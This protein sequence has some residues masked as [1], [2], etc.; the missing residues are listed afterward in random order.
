MP[1]VW[2]RKVGETPTT[3]SYAFGD[4]PDAVRGVVVI[5]VDDVDACHLEG[6]TRE[7]LGPDGAAVCGK[8]VRTFRAS[9]AWPQ[10]AHHFS[11]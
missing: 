11:C 2:G 5:P 3:V 9:G 8:A 4:G 10:D 1:T 7:D 6:G